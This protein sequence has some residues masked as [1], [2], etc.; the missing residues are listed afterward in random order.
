MEKRKLNQVKVS[1]GGV[2]K[3]QGPSQTEVVYGSGH[4]GEDGNEERAR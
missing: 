1:V 2:G 3:V 4:K